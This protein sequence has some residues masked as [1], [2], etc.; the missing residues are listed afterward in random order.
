MARPVRKV[1]GC[2]GIPPVRQFLFDIFYLNKPDIVTGIAKG[3][4]EQEAANT[5]PIVY[6]GAYKAK[7]KNTGK[8]Y[9]FG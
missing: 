9:V 4:S 7:S 5:I 2:C 1:G 6:K 8:E 3:Q